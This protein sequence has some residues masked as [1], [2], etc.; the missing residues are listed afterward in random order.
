[1]KLH[2]FLLFQVGNQYMERYT[3]QISLD[4]FGL[5]AQIKLSKIK[6]LIV[7]VGGLGC[8]LAT[9]LTAMGV[10]QMGLIDGDMVSLSNLHRQ[11]LFTENN[12]GKNKAIVAAKRLKEI[13]SEVEFMVMDHH[14]TPKN[15]LAMVRD[16]DLIIDCTD[17]IPSKYLI[18][19]LCTIYDK[20]WIHGSLFKNQG[21][22]A[23]FNTFNGICF[24]ANYRDV[25]EENA[26]KN[27]I[28]S[29][30][31]G[32]IMGHLPTIVASM[33]TEVFV[34]WILNDTADIENKIIHFQSF[35]LT[36]FSITKNKNNTSPID[37]KSFQKMHLNQGGER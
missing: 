7:G 31:G 12:I 32:G 27:E 8:P 11:H 29:C 26:G 16:F 14:L 21:Q 3:R 23:L 2:Y 30:E 19:D 22:F 15:G 20:P 6:V 34:Q 24:S 9:Q 25:Y 36:H 17:D 35:K 28:P 5:E 33:M 1:M 10:G 4:Y 13:N 18:N 37:L